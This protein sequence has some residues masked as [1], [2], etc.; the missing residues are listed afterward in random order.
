MDSN[1]NVV[2]FPGADETKSVTGPARCMACRHT[3]QAVVSHETRLEPLECSQCGAMKGIL[4]MPYVPASGTPVW[5]CS[6]GNDLFYIT[7]S[8]HVCPNCGEIVSIG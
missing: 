4:V 1:S 2:K 6:C 5:K 7:R 8:G 3:W